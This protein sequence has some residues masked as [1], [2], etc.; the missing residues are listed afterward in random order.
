MRTV[1][2]GDVHG[3]LQELDELLRVVQFK[4]PNNLI[5]VGD[6]LDKGP[7]S[8][9]VVRRV[10]E[11]GGVLVRGNHEGKHLRLSRGKSIDRP[12]T[13]R[14]VQIQ[15]SLSSEDVEFLR[16]S[17]LHHQ[18]PGDAGVVVHGGIPIGLESLESPGGT[19]E[20]K[21][22]YRELPFLRYQD[23]LFWAWGYDGRFGHCYFGHQPFMQQE[24]AQYPH[25]TGL[26]LGCCYGG[27]LC[28]A[29]LE[30]DKVPAF[31]TVQARE[32]YARK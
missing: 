3:C 18:L 24:P 10:R 19:A 7:D 29:I 27:R 31:V 11:L 23:Q 17:R 22:L 13:S 8:V 25:A 30:P 12:P 15:L 14:E 28:A 26:D 9:G 2:V 1:V 21:S 4:R 20:Q 32:A 6:L 16:T 5:F